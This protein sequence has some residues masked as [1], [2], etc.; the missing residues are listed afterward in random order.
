V[1]RDH[2]DQFFTLPFAGWIPFNSKLFPLLSLTVL[3]VVLVDPLL[4]RR[5]LLL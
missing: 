5:P 4:A 3:A 2:F 1:K